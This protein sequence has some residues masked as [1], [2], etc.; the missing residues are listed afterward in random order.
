MVAPAKKVT[1]PKT[2]PKTKKAIKIKKK[3]V[4]GP[5]K[6]QQKAAATRSKLLAQLDTLGVVVK[7]IEAAIAG[8]VSDAERN[9]KLRATIKDIKD[10][11]KAAEKA[12]KKE[13]VE[14]ARAEKKAVAAKARAE[15]K[16]A[17]AKEKLL[18]Q[19]KTL[20]TTV[21]DPEKRSVEDLKEVLALKRSALSAERKALKKA[22]AEKAKYVTLVQEYYALPGAG[23]PP[24]G[25]AEIRKAIRALKKAQPVAPQVELVE[26]P[27]DSIVTST[28]TMYG[29]GESK[30]PQTALEQVKE[31]FGFD[32]VEDT[33][34]EFL[35]AHSSP[36]DSSLYG[37]KEAPFAITNTDDIE[38]DE[39]IEEEEE[40]IDL[41][42]E[43]KFTHEGV[44]YYKVGDPNGTPNEIVFT[45]EGE[46]IGVWDGEN[47]CILAC[48][49]EE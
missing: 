4:K 32:E 15:K 27:V 44:E 7:D 49:F 10:K 21:L 46:A 29:G 2:K 45:L 24:V 40:A 43:M 47:S 25:L 20:G 17:A 26:E 28:F 48:E 36:V 11:Q 22:E 39:E 14:K 5:N 8:C 13:A 16:Q 38:T 33:L 42:P 18:E 31:A 3:V 12:A 6:K 30:G 1:K 19:L 34:P 37:S 9:A 35:Q 41:S 23:V